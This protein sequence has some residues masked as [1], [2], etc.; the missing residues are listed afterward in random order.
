M[1]GTKAVSASYAIGVGG[2]KGVNAQALAAL[3]QDA[4]ARCG[5]DL[6]RAAFAALA[7]REDEEEFRKA[8]GLVGAALVLLPLEKLR[9]READ[10]LT[11]SPRVKAMFGVG[12]LVEALA[13]VAAGEGSRLLAPRFSTDRLSCAIAEPQD[14]ASG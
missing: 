13:L 12:S 1:A 3:T 11:H 9:G 2:R 4:A 10:L 6:E 8:A 14:G 7:G 5:V